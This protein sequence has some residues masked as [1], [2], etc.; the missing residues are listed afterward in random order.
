MMVH[1]LKVLGVLM[2]CYDVE[3]VGEEGEDGVSIDDK[4]VDLKK[5][6]RCIQMIE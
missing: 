4:C 3:G 5:G 2:V 1:D 6:L